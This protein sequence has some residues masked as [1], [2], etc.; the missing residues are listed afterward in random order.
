[1]TK[2]INRP[3]SWWSK[4]RASTKTILAERHM[5]LNH[6]GLSAEEIEKIYNEIYKPK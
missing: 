6:D 3:L 5:K 2:P 1:M 4:L